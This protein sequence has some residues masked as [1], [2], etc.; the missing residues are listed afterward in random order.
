MHQLP[1]STPLPRFTL[2]DLHPGNFAMVMASGIISIGF[3]A[4]QFDLL[5]DAL[6]IFALCAWLAQ[7]GAPA[8]ARAWLRRRPTSDDAGRGSASRGR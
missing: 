3:N 4:F 6:F 7:G 5:A 1:A 8:A 2:Q